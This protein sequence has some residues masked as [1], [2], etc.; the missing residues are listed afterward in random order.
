MA[1]YIFRR[2]EWN[3]A[4][5]QY[6]YSPAARSFTEFT[7]EEDGIVNRHNPEI[8]D[9][10]YVS[11]VTKEAFGTGTRIKTKCSFASYGAPLIVLGN[12]FQT[13]TEGRLRYGLHFEVVAWEEGCNVWHILPAPERTERPIK[14]T[15]IGAKTFP[16]APGSR[17]DLEVELAQKALKIKV[18][19]EEMTVF[20]ED[21]PET[22]HVGITAC[23]G[24][25]R[26]SEFTVEP[27]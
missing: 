15:K 2:G 5:F 10:D 14:P 18:N 1:H 17:I 20:S 13:D 12:D 8:D 6:V 21:L 16:I 7:Q 11:M 19:G 9:F 22:C 26:F 23:E 27:M 24:I 4:E 25:N 3:P